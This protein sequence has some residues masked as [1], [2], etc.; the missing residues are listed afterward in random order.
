MSFPFSSEAMDATRRIL[1]CIED[2]APVSARVASSLGIL[3]NSVQDPL[4]E[5][6][7]ERAATTMNLVNADKAGVFKRAGILLGYAVPFSRT[8]LPVRA[9]D[10]C[11]DREIEIFQELEALLRRTEQEVKAFLRDV[12]DLPHP[13]VGFPASDADILHKRTLRATVGGRGVV[14]AFEDGRLKITDESAAVLC[15][16]PMAGVSFG[17]FK[18]IL[19]RIATM[20]TQVAILKQCRAENVGGARWEF[21]IDGREA[22]RVEDECFQAG[23]HCAKEATDTPPVVKMSVLAYDPIND[24]KFPD[25]LWREFSVD[26]VFPGIIEPAPNKWPE[27]DRASAQPTDAPGATG[28]KR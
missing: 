5:L 19:E 22:V 2:L 3:K 15:D 4:D 25:R 26:G 21:L 11:V 23:I 8:E 17:L 16:A 27:I 14:A 13:W 9:C 12:D 24:G 20:L 6:D 10:V 18:H 28:M 7:P 1:E